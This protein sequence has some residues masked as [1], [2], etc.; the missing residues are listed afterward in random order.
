MSGPRGGRCGTAAGS[1]APC[2]SLLF[3]VIPCCSP[4]FPV[5]S[6]SS[7]SADSWHNV[8]PL[9]TSRSSPGAGVPLPLRSCSLPC[10]PPLGRAPGARCPLPRDSHT[11]S[12]AQPHGDTH[13]GVPNLS[14]S[15][16]PLPGASPALLPP[17]P[18]VAAGLPPLPGDTQNPGG[19]M[20]WAPLGTPSPLIREGPRAS[21]TLPSPQWHRSLWQGK[22]LIFLSGSRSPDT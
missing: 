2:Y 8:A 20:V 22:V 21:V 12:V 9:S 3:L 16:L 7:C 15:L 6:N 18:A 19:D 1:I 4:L 17:S 13:R 11:C 5:P 14:P 10:S